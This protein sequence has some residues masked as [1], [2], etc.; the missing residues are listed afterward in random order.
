VKKIAQIV[1]QHIFCQHEFSITF[2][3]IKAAQFLAS[4]KNFKTLPIVN[5]RPTD[6]NSPNLVTLGLS[7]HKKV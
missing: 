7:A 6:E 5:S 2:S 4:Y 1:A 3:V